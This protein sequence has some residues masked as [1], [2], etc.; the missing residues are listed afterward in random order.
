MDFCPRALG[1]LDVPGYEVGVRMSFKYR[2]D[3]QFFALGRFQVILNIALGID[4]RRF[5]S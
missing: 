5:P 1:Q 2:D 4:Y 3:F